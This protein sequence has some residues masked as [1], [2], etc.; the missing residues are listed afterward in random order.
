MPYP[1]VIDPARPGR[2]MFAAIARASYSTALSLTESPISEGGVWSSQ[3]TTRTR[4]NTSG[5]V[6]FGTQTG[7]ESTIYADSYAYHN[8]VWSPNVE[9]ISTVFKGTTSGIQEV[10]HLHRVS[11]TSSSTVCYE[12]NIA[13]DGSYCDFYRWTGPNL[14]VGDFVPLVPSLTYSV[15]GGAVNN[16]DRI[17]TSI[18]GNAL[19][20][21]ID[22]GAGW[23][24]IN[25]SPV[26][27]TAGAGGG[28]VLT[29]GRPGIGFFK[30]AVSGAMNQYAWADFS[31]VEL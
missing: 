11:D 13:H 17:R 21:W 10:E 2:G 3:D 16:G 8:G 24:L 19:N 22:R 18:V 4:I 1:A 14:V 20:A 27:D 30:T 26:T 12:I 23:V 7:G 25:S 5:G 15:P 9:I 28:A 29:S 6:A 31:A